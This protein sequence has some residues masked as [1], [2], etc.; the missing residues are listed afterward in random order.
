M[1]PDNPNV[2]CCGESDAD[3]ADEIHVRDGKT[4][5]T[6]TDDR[7]DE[8]RRR[9]HIDVGTVVEIPNHKLKWDKSNPDRARRL[10]HEPR[11]LRL[12]LRAARRRVAARA[13]TGLESLI[14]SDGIGAG[15][16]LFCF[17]AFFRANRA[18]Y[19][20]SSCRFSRQAFTRLSKPP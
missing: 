18:L 1:Q 3:W 4:Y 12:L 2:S 9:P 14:R 11:R 17:D 13:R 16:C 7:P 10:V 6:V 19:L 20:A 5:A 8:P 15:L